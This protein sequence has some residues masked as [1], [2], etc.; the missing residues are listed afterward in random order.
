ML[1]GWGCLLERL[2]QRAGTAS[3]GEFLYL[4]REGEPLRLDEAWTPHRQ[5]FR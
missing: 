4:L 1:P 3:R 5:A 2:N